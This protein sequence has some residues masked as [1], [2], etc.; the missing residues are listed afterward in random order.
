MADRAIVYEANQLRVEAT[1]G[2]DPGTGTKLMGA[3]NFDLA[4]EAD[5]DVFG[6]MGQKFDTLS[7]LNRE[8]VSGGV[9]G[10]PTYTEIIYPLSSIMATP[11]TT[12]P[13]GATT[14]RQHVFEISNASADAYKTFTLE[15]G[16]QG[17]GLGEKSTNVALTELGITVSRDSGMDMSG[18]AIGRAMTT[19]VTT[20][21][22]PTA[23]DLVPIMP[24]QVSV[25]LDDTAAGIG[26]TKLLR[27][28]EIE[29]RIGDRRAPIWPINAALVS[30][31]GTIETR[32]APTVRLTLGNDTVGQGILTTMRNGAK[33]F[34]RIEAI[35]PLIETTITYK[36]TI[37]AC[38][39]VSTAPGRGDTNGLSTLDWTFRIA[40]DATWG[41]A[42]IITVVNNLASL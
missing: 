11:I 36:L 19:G 32:P 31:D 18:N 39:V 28:F 40:R 12:T 29:W 17:A 9:T 6:P 23:I 1:P 20:D 34:V 7:V 2:T 10:R 13:G 33:K 25:Y 15:R 8:W 22:A 16:Q 30:Y 38:L 37:D 4:V 42:C 26:T 21:A 24:G 27:D 5:L 35:G 3:L 41:H 14:A